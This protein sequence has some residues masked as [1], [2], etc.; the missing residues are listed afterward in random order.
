MEEGRVTGKGDRGGTREGGRGEGRRRTASLFGSCQSLWPLY[1]APRRDGNQPSFCSKGGGRLL[2]GGVSGGGGA[3][4]RPRPRAPQ[5]L[6]WFVVPAFLSTAWQPEGRLLLHLLRSLETHACFFFCFSRGVGMVF[7]ASPPPAVG[8]FDV[9]TVLATAGFVP[10]RERVFW[11]GTN[12]CPDGKAQHPSAG[13]ASRGCGLPPLPYTSFPIAP[14]SP[15][16]RCT[17][18]RVLTRQ[19]RCHRQSFPLEEHGLPPAARHTPLPSLESVIR[20]RSQRGGDGRPPFHATHEGWVCTGTARRGCTV[21][22][23]SYCLLGR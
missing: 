8:P 9:S 12:G 21:R 6:R 23:E 7:P 1:S 17:R 19:C 2:P 13:E 22:R 16:A 4:R 11:L 15:L 18:R 20:W 5:T 3:G 14:T 10:P